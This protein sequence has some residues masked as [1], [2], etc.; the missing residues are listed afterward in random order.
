M[1]PTKP[2][3]FRFGLPVAAVALLLILLILIS[4]SM[5]IV[6]EDEQAVVARFGRPIRTI[7]GAR[8]AIEQSNIREQID[9]ANGEMNLTVSLTFGAGFYFKVPF[10]DEVEFFEN[11]LLQFDAPPTEAVTLDKQ[12]VMIDTFAR[13]RIS[14]P[15][16]YRQSMRTEFEAQNRL[17]SIITN[18]VNANV[19]KYNFSEIIRTTNRILELE[20]EEALSN[21]VTEVKVGR[22]KIMEEVTQICDTSARVVGIRIYDLR[23]KRADLPEANRERVYSRMQEERKR[24][25]TRFRE[26]GKSKAKKIRADTD[27]TVRVML[28]EADRKK[29][30]LEGDA[31]AG[32]MRI[33]AQGFEETE[34]GMSRTF[35]GYESDPQFY[36]F[37]RQLEALETIADETQ[38]VFVSS[39]DSEIFSLLKSQEALWPKDT[40]RSGSSLGRQ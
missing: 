39:T 30:I 23:I 33:Y 16:L 32:A 40:A 4:S 18:D 22:A 7:A 9:I 19:A 14:N 15:L 27:K 37:L 35:L 38:T 10:L 36:R 20:R 8:E 29:R 13:W 28:A 6:R 11:R 26:N 2:L 21:L 5:F 1:T 24:I 34:S 12:R 31:D 3:A 17:R 25:S